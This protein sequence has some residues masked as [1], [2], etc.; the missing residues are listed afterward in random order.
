MQLRFI[1]K[2]IEVTDALKTITT[3]KMH[4]LQKR[5][6]SIATINIVFSVEHQ[7]HAAEATLHFEG[8]DIHA[9]AEDNDMY[10]AIDKLVDKLATQLTKQKDKVID[11]HR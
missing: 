4:T 7:T 11:K 9:H 3:E 2:N 8:H 5:F 10:C 1:G 6:S